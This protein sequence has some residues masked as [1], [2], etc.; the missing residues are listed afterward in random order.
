MR[1]DQLYKINPN[2]VGKCII[3]NQKLYYKKGLNSRLGTDLDCSRL[4]ETFTMLGYEVDVLNHVIYSK[5]AGKLKKVADE[6]EEH[7]S[8]LVVCILAHGQKGATNIQ[9]KNCILIIKKFADVIICPDG[10]EYPIEKIKEIF[11]ATKCRYLLQKPKIFFI[12]ACQG[13]EKLAGK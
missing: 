11:D 10:T 1:D 7:C 12:Q 4:E 2:N 6:I 9:I 3:I 5:M 8:S 13:D